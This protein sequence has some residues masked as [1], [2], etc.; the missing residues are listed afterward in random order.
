MPFDIEIYLLQINFLIFQII[1]SLHT[2]SLTAR[3]PCIFL[4]SF[5]GHELFRII[6]IYELIGKNLE[7]KLET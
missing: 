5:G 1:S 4:Y 6:T 2:T 3:N 7:K